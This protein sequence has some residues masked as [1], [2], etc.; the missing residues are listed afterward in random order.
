MRVTRRSGNGDGGPA[1]AEKR[2]A[3]S[4]RYEHK[5]A[6][7]YLRQMRAEREIELAM[8]STPAEAI[9]YERWKAAGGQYFDKLD[10]MRESDQ[11]ARERRAA[12]TTPGSGDIF[13]RRFGW[14]K[15]S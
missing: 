12:S 15:N 2:L 8:T 6:D 13:R 3:D 14:N 7:R 11:R 1:A 4:E 9:A 10:E 5:R